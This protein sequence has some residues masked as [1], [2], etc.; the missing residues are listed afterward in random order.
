MVV[1]E[2]MDDHPHE[3]ATAMVGVFPRGDPY[4]D[5]WAQFQND[6]LERGTIEQQN[7]N[8]TAMSAMFAMIKTYRYA[9]R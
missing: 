9:E 4:M 6:A 8:N 2:I 7:S 5:E 3:L 1:R